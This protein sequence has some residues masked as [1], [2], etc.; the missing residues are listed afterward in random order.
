M[1]TTDWDSINYPAA[2]GGALTVEFT[3]QIRFVEIVMSA[4][5]PLQSRVQILSAM[6]LSGR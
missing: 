2:C 6:Y 5:R 3:A 4:L 1:I